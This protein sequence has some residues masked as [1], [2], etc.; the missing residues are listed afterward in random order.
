M[1]AAEVMAALNTVEQDHQIV[2]DKAQALKETVGCLIDPAGLDPHRVLDRLRDISR[3]CGT[4]LEAHMEEEEVTL[5]PLLEGHHPE[6]P[7]L[8]T[9]LRQE[10]AEIRRKREEFDNCLHVAGDLEDDLPER[11]LTDLLA[12]G[13][14]L[15]E[16][17]DAHAHAEAQAVHRGL[18]RSL[19]DDRSP[20][21]G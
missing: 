19:L 14:D 20:G 8:V 18:V 9:R 10:H 11:V 6:G 17:L 15:W 4:Q 3:Y 13:W 2:L 16:A 7:E 5:F 21:Q 12:Y 1:N